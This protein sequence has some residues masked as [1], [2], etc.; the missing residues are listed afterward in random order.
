MSSKPVSAACLLSAVYFCLLP[1]AC[2]LLP[3]IEQ[4]TVSDR[5]LILI[6][7][8]TI[9]WV[10]VANEVVPLDVSDKWAIWEEFG[11]FRKRIVFFSPVK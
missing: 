9:F 7:L 1:A 8:G 5:Q 3:L 2:C 6:Y 4:L 11:V 10:L